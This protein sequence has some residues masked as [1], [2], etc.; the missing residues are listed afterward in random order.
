MS[1]EFESRIWS[2]HFLLGDHFINSHN[3]LSL[4]NVRISLGQNWDLKGQFEG[5]SHCLNFGKRCERAPLKYSLNLNQQHHTEFQRSPIN[6]L[7]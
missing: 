6:S 1:R 2:K 4:D 5:S 3:L 7:A